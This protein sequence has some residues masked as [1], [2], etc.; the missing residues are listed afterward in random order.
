MVGYGHCKAALRLCAGR[1][2]LLCYG[3]VHVPASAP[4][5]RRGAEGV[6]NLAQREPGPPA[7]ELWTGCS[8]KSRAGQSH[9][10]QQILPRN[11]STGTKPYSRSASVYPGARLSIP[12]RKNSAGQSP[13]A[14]RGIPSECTLGLPHAFCRDEGLSTWPPLVVFWRRST[15]GSARSTVCAGQEEI[16]S[17]SGWVCR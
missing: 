6:A 4:L 13:G 2:G 9:V 10:L 12:A 15:A 11:P 17:T 7:H 1:A 5:R 8:N 3:C 14:G 16:E